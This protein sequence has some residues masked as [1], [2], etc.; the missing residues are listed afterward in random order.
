MGGRARGLETTSLIDRDIDHHRALPHAPDHRAVD[1]LWRTC[2]GDKDS[3]DNDV[4]RNDFGLECVAMSRSACEPVRR[5]V[6][7]SCRSRGSERSR[8]VTSATQPGGHSSGMAADHAAADDNDPR[9]RHARNA[10]QQETP[11]ACGPSQLNAAA[12]IASRP[13]TSLMGAKSGSPPWTSVTV[14]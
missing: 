14:S 9:R 7:S 2:T 10:A 5:T 11:A 3:A 13:A 1:Q 4:G 12:S 6:S 8:T